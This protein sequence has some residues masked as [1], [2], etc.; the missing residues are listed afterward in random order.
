MKLVFVYLGPGRELR[1]YV[2]E[3]LPRVDLHVYSDN[4]CLAL[5]WLFWTFELQW[6]YRACAA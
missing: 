6:R 3:V 2:L 1:S 5:G 4:G